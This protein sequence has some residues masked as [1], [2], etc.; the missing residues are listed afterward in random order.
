MPRSV[1][2]RYPGALARAG[3]PAGTRRGVAGTAARRS[4][5]AGHRR[6]QGGRRCGRADHGRSVEAIAGIGDERTAD[7]IPVLVRGRFDDLHERDSQSLASSAGGSPSESSASK[8]Y[9]WTKSASA[10]WRTAVLMKSW[11][12]LVGIGDPHGLVRISIAVGT[13]ISRAR[14]QSV[15]GPLSPG[16]AAPAGSPV[17][18]LAPRLPREPASRA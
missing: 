14:D 4:A 9:S 5:R 2:W 3:R 13:L 11:T 7:L 12:T 17:P 18:D 10:S 1:G 16:A 6:S 8:R 15:G